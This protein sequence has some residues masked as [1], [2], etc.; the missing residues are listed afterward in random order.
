MT[1]AGPL[2]AGA[3][4]PLRIGSGGGLLWLAVA[5]FV[6]ALFAVAAGLGG[7]AGVSMDIAK[8]LVVVFLVLAVV[9]LL[10]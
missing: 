9:A 7:V 6:I 10:L 3:L 1:P 8:V 2:L 5:F 4:V